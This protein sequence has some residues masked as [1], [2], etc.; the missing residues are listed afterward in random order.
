MSKKNPVL[1]EDRPELGSLL[2]TRGRKLNLTEEEWAAFEVAFE[3]D[4]TPAEPAVFEEI[5]RGKR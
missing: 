5:P 3:R 1:K 4:R 2:A